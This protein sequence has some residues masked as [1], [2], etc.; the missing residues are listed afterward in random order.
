MHDHD[1]GFNPEISKIE[2]ENHIQYSTTSIVFKFKHITKMILS[3]ARYNTYGTFY[4]NSN[5]Y[6]FFRNFFPNFVICDFT[7]EFMIDMQY[8]S[9]N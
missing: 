2:Q 6:K 8:K 7:T 9:F 5:K 1:E 4:K 3:T